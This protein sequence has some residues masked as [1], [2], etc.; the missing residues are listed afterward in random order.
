MALLVVLGA[1]GHQGG[2]VID[3]YLNHP[4]QLNFKLRGVTRNVGSEASRELQSKGVDMAEAD[5]GDKQALQKAFEGA[6]H[7]FSNSDSNQMIFSAIK[8]P[9]LLRD[10]QTAAQYGAEQEYQLGLNIIEA[11]A[12]TETLQRII[13]STLPSPKKRSKGKYS[14]VAMFDVKDDIASL[15]KSDARL[16]HKTNFLINGFYLDNAVRVPNLYAPKLQA[17]GVYELSFPMSGDAP[18]PFSDISADQGKWV[19]ALLNAPAGTTLFGAT[20][21]MGWAQWLQAW[22]S[23]LKVPVRYVRVAPDDFASDMKG[24]QHAIAE[25]LQYVEEF[26]FVEGEEGIV[27]LDVVSCFVIL[28]SRLLQTDLRS[29]IPS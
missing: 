11:A 21:T 1:T 9:E 5:L 8:K 4:S 17:D 7:I 28:T 18:V 25:E 3:Y 23:H 16:K 15:F 13:W 20:Q 22:G 10:G 26:G 6:T 14:K 2:A 24:I 19:E 27:T 29:L 12:A